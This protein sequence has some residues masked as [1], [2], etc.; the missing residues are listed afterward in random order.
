MKNNNP[1]GIILILIGMLIFSIQD[2]I[3]KY[4]YNSVSLYEIYIIRTLVS[5]SII[6]LFLKLTKKPIIFKTHYPFLTF[7]RVILFFF[8]FSS[9]YISLTIM[10]LVTATAL[11][12]VTP[13]LITIFAKFFLKDQIGLRRW[14]AVIIGFI[15]IYIILNP[16]FDNFNYLKLTPILCAFCYSLSMIIIK[17]TSDKDDVYQQMFQFYIGALIISGTFYFLIGDGQYNTINNPAA[18]FIFREWFSNLEF[19][20]IYLIILGFTASVGFLLLFSAYRIASPAVVSPFEYS[21]LVW[22][23]L[24]GWFFFDEIPGIR[25]IFGIILI[26]CGGIYIFIREKAQDQSIVT[27]KPLR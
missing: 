21:I 12:F 7:C 1:K 27:E 8:G 26:V 5:F 14:S 9:F 22:S 3:M 16:N 24:S 19:S 23:S 18:Q 11:F 17:K 15:G 25:T 10:P 13:F 2:S 6:L 20:L 4:I